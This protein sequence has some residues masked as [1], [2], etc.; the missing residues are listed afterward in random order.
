MIVVLH[1]SANEISK[2]FIYSFKYRR[3]S[4]YCDNFYIASNINQI[5]PQPNNQISTELFKIKFK[6]IHQNIQTNLTKHIH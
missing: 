2:C 3:V 4:P 6:Q 1:Y 5:I